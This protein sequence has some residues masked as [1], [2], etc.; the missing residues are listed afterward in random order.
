MRIKDY[1]SSII[2]YDLIHRFY[3]TT[4]KQPKLKTLTISTL[5]GAQTIKLDK[6]R[7]ALEILTQKKPKIIKAK[8]SV[9][10][11]QLRSG[12]S[13][14]CRVTLRANSLYQFLDQLQL[15]MP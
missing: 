15:I 2:E 14:G 11:F 13:I 6:A 5:T 1:Y 8:T 7:L 9:A 12:M 10:G 3:Y 4:T